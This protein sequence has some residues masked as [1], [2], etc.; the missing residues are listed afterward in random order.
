[1][2]PTLIVAHRRE[3]TTRRIARAVLDSSGAMDV[4]AWIDGPRDHNEVSQTRTV[5][6][7]LRS[8]PW[9]GSF[10]IMENAE[11]LGVAR[12]VPSALDWV[13]ARRTDVVVLEDDCL[14]TPQF[15]TFAHEMLNRFRH[16]RR[17]AIVSGT[18]IADS[19]FPQEGDAFSFSSFPLIWGWATWADR[20]DQYSHDIRGWRREY[21]VRD[22]QR[23]GGLLH[24]WD[25]YRLFNSVATDE[26]WSWDYQLTYM[27]WRHHQ[28]AVV[29]GVDLVEN[30]GFGNLATHTSVK[31]PWAPQPPDELIRQMMIEQLEANC[32]AAVAADPWVD[33]ELRRLLFSPPLHSRIRSRLPHLPRRPKAS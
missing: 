20:W 11:N 14:P 12:A 5:A 2:V 19:R 17:V 33:S 31:P 21:G 24:A 9:P 27:V 16:D 15:F 7:V 6:H 10:Q 8:Q 18:R 29:P 1:M 25:W 32:K 23:Q 26:P 13:L 30:I 4:W 22:L 28:V 3:E